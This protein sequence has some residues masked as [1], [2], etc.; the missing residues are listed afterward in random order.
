[1]PGTHLG[2]KGYQGV[3]HT[4]ERVF[5]KL[6]DG[7]KHSSE[8]VDREAHIYLQLRDLWGTAVPKMISHG[9]WGFCHIILL[10]FVEVKC[11]WRFVPNPV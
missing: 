6:W 11:P 7:W 3:L 2:G 9:G 8:E 10:E 4:G 5:A 1:L